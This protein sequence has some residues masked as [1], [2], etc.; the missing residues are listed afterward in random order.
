MESDLSYILVENVFVFAMLFARFGTAISIMPG[1]GDFFTPVQVRLLLA[2]SLCFALTPIFYP[3]FP[4]LPSNT[5]VLVQAVA[6]EF[7]IG[8]MIGVMARI[9]MAALDTGGMLISIQTG[10]GNAQIFNPGAQTQGSLVGTFFYLLGVVL[11]F[12]T[13]LHHIMIYAIYESYQMMPPLNAPPFN[14]ISDLMARAISH[15]FLI[16]FKIG[17]PFITIGLILYL[18]MGVMGRLMPQI[19]I[20]ILALP[21]QILVGFLVL[22][23]IVSPI[24]LYWIRTF[25]EGM[26]L[27]LGLR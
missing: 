7:I 15:S 4:E 3:I 24:M 19:Q 1:F 13:N 17:V 12:A 27:F 5:V 25:E 20:F 11:I 16:G 26:T 14:I 2:V 10:L 9:F 8:G 22:S 18:A 6:Y 21:L 23:L